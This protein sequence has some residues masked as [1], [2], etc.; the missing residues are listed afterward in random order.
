MFSYPIMFLQTR[1]PEL[2]ETN[3]NGI[4]NA[5]GCIARQPEL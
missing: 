3:F 4:C 2:R 1:W 5:L